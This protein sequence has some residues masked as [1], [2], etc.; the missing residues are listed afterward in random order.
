VNDGWRDG[1]VAEGDGLLIKNCPIN[2]SKQQLTCLI[3]GCY[4]KTIA[5]ALGTSKIHYL[6]EGKRSV[7]MD[8]LKQ[9]SGA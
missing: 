4:N 3:F 9:N 2:H 7:K 1:R 6:D 8:F 5:T